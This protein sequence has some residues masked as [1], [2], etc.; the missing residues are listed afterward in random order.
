VKQYAHVPQQT[1][2]QADWLIGA[3]L[4][5][6]QVNGVALRSMKDPGT[7]FD[8]PLL[9]KDP[10]PA[11]MDDY[12]YTGSDNGGVHINSGIPNRAFYLLAVALGGFAWEKAG[13]IWYATLRDSRLSSTA[14][15]QEFA[16]LTTDNADKLFGAVERQAVINAWQQVGILVQSSPQTNFVASAAAPNGDVHT[17]ALDQAN[18]LWHTI[19]SVNGD[20]PYPWGDVQQA[21]RD[22]GNLDVGPTRF[23]AAAAAPNGDLHLLVLDQADG[24]WHTIRAANGDWPYPWGDVQQAIR[25]QGNPDV[26]PTKFVATTAAANGDL[27]VFVL[28]QADSLWHTIRLANGDWPYPW[29]NVQAALPAPVLA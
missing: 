21:I 25:D 26:G 23:V 27:H 24:L 17:L 9:G 11:H 1:A 2:D 29:G 8:D 12:N 3:G 4:F 6:A 22:Q 14:S 15:F 18:G 10:Q 20:W 28:D 5:T 7:A 13:R 19:R 16:D